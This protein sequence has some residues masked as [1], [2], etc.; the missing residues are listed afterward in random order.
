MTKLKIKINNIHCYVPHYTP[1]IRQQ[2]ILTK[3]IS[4]RTRTELRYIEL[5]IP[6]KE[7]YDQNLWTF[8]L[9]FEQGGSVPVRIILGFQQ[10]DR[11]K[12][13]NLVND[14]FCRPQ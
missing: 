6:I 1:P 9:R 3:K 14:T 11:Q 4:S 7:V 12:S 2:G 10:R 5:S 8:E 13:Q